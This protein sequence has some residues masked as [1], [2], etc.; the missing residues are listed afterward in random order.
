MKNEI[1]LPGECC[2][3]SKKENLKKNRLIKNFP[4]GVDLI[5]ELLK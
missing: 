4:D 3:M 5:K 2:K 1:N